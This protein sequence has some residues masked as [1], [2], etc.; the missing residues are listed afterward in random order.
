MIPALGVD[1][2]RTIS[3]ETAG[4]SAI[5]GALRQGI[6]RGEAER[7]EED[8]S[9]VTMEKYIK[10]YTGVSNSKRTFIQ[11]HPV[12]F[13]Q[14]FSKSPPLLPLSC[15]RDSPAGCQCWPFGQ[16]HV[17]SQLQGHAPPPSCLLLDF[18]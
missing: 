7:K 2:G 18:I 1:K 4:R 6:G 9:I 12:M 8:D 11:T 15:T 10:Q 13:H 3:K 16:S 14:F 5:E 17:H